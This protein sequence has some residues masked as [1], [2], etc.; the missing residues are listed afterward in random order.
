MK[1]SHGEF[2]S[3]FILI[4]LVSGIIFSSYAF[5]ELSQGNYTYELKTF[6]SYEEIGSFLQAKYDN[7]TRSYGY[8]ASQDLG[9]SAPTSES[10]NWQKTVTNGEADAETPDYS[11][12]NIQVEGVDEPDIVKTDGTYLYVIA[13]Q[14]VYI[15]QGYPA[16][17]AEILAEL[18]YD[19]DISLSGLFIND[20]RLVVLGNTYE[21]TSN[22]G[23]D[24]YYYG[25]GGRSTAVI[26]VYDL[27]SPSNP[28]LVRDVTVDGYYFDSRMIGDYVYIV[29]SENS[30]LYYGGYI[31]SNRSVPIP[32]MTVD[33][34]TI[35]LPPDEIYYVDIPEPPE[36][37]TYVVSLN[38]H[39]STE[40]VVEKGFLIGNAQTMYVSQK[41][42]YIAY[43]QYGY[44]VVSINGRSQDE[45]TTLLHRIRIRNG[46]IEYT[47]QGE[48]PG[49]ILNQFSMDEH[50][51]YFRIATTNGFSWNDDAQNNIYIL[52]MDLNPVSN[53]ENIAPG[54]T[55]YS[56]RF[57]GDRAYLVTFKKI[58]PFFTIDLSDPTNPQIIGELKIPGYSDYLHPYD[59]DHIIGL[60]KDT[61]EATEEEGWWRDFS[62]AWYQGLKIALFDVSDFANPTV[63]D[64]VIIGD[65]GTDSPA[66]YDHKA[67]L[68]DK[69]KELLV[70]PIRIYEIN[71]SIK[72][73]YDELPGNTYGEFTFQG[74]Y[75]YKLTLDNGFQYQGRI[76]HLEDAAD[77]QNNP[78]GYWGT[79]SIH[80]SLYIGSTLYTISQHMIKMHDLNTLTE[81]NSITL[82]T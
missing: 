53:I 71:N 59:N 7:Y 44:H 75:I 18:T 43:I 74:A 81:L 27:T 3:L 60:G 42:I 30:Y 66:L 26:K 5:T 77:L 47:A 67:F 28:E 8:E 63:L 23:E 32:T 17:N 2:K 21:H 49:R 61:V 34:E 68:F 82:T 39:D 14:T 40:E 65:R 69:N 76:T 50:N 54:E 13:R 41:N 12:T 24:I 78:Y 45:Q 16:E 29:C 46:D 25:W 1:K 55:I 79:S 73:E 20:N 52:D 80:R 51:G 48:V 15:I 37:L 56:A 72:N 57:I 62:F 33:D 9:A 4:L 19:T 38:I 70:I 10:I 58:D 22:N 64:Q 35:E 36:T 31:E 11:E 6:S